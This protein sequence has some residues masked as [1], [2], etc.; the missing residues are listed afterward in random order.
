V[1][2]EFVADVYVDSVLSLTSWF[3]AIQREQ[4]LELVSTA[5]RFWLI[6]D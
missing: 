3:E 2:A 5:G 6:Y 1:R 4:E